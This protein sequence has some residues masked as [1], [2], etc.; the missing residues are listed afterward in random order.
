MCNTQSANIS[1]YFQR[2]MANIFIGSRWTWSNL[3]LI[4]QDSFGYK[5]VL[6]RV[7]PTQVQPSVECP[8][9]ELNALFF[10]CMLLY[11]TNWWE[12]SLSPTCNANFE[13]QINTI[14]GWK[15]YTQKACEIRIVN[16]N[17]TDFATKLHILGLLANIE[18]LDNFCQLLFNF[19]EQ[20]FLLNLFQAFQEKRSGLRIQESILCLVILEKRSEAQLPV[21]IPTLSQK[22]NFI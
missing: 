22:S 19:V 11:F 12:A 6:E 17:K 16:C 7:D 10:I 18:D 9:L 13:K 1:M 15:W 4:P 5:A 8:A 21:K 2:N 3:N 20:L 14:G